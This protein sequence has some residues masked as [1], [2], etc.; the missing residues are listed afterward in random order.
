MASFERQLVNFLGLKY[1]FSHAR[2]L[3]GA[4]PFIALVYMV[5]HNEQTRIAATRFAWTAVILNS[6]KIS[7]QF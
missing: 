7:G 5:F 1:R 4:H 3:R 2:I 6:S